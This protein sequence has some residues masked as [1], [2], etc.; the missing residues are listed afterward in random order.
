MPLRHV[1]GAAAGA[2]V[3]AISLPG[4]AS[5]AQGEF[6]YVYN[7]SSGTPQAGQLTDP[8]SGVCLTLPEV[9]S[10]WTTPAHTPRNFTGSTATVFAG[11]DCSGPYFS[12]RPHVGHASER[13]KVRSVVFS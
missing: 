1:L 12:L 10:D 2:L 11:T 5:A 7:D 9:A 3:L 8:P 4:S 13:L 6:T